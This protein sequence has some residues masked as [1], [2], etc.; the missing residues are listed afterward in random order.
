MKNFRFRFSEL[1]KPLLVAQAFIFLVAGFDTSSSTISNAL[2]ELA[3]HQDVQDKLRNEIREHYE[4]NNGEWQYESIKK[5][6][7]LDVVF[8]GVYTVGFMDLF[9]PSNTTQVF[10]QE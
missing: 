4:L 10:S 3:Q 5:M 7:I 2:Y 9:H 8:K 6:P 1:T